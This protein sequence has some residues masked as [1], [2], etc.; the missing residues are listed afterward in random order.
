M[1]RQPPRFSVV[2]GSLQ[3]DPILVDAA[4][5]MHMRVRRVE[6]GD[7]IH[8]FDDTG[9]EVEAELIAIDAGGARA[10][11]IR[12]IVGIVEPALR[13]TLVQVV[14]VKLQRMDTIVRQASEIF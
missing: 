7:L 6:A 2:G 11:L 1:S 13:C 14:P 3:G 5:A 10:R 4:E 8:L 12:S 9:A